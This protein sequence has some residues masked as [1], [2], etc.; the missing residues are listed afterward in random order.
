MK[1]CHLT[2]LLCLGAVGAAAYLGARG[3]ADRAA[4]A[5]AE[6]APG[7]FRSPGFPAGYALVA[8]ETALLIDPP[9]EAP[10]G[11]CSSSAATRWRRR[12]SSGR[13]TPPTGTTGPTPG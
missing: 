5:W 13:P 9:G 4:A 2:A 3:Y 12:A 1:R 8:G 11:R 6:V 10:A 7:V